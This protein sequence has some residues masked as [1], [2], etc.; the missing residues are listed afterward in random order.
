MKKILPAIFITALLPGISLGFDE[1]AEL[2]QAITATNEFAGAL[3]SEL[4]EAMQSGG[5][6]EAIEVCNTQALTISEEVSQEN[7]LTLSRVSL[8]NRN[9]GNAPNSWQAA[10]LINFENRHQAGED[11]TALTWQG[12]AQTDSGRE[13][14]FMK[15][16]PTG[17]LCLQCH[18][19]ALAPPVAEKLTE[20]YPS[21]KATGFNVGDLRGAFV[22]IRKLD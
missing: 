12:I 2:E 22:V 7:N 15:A 9:P 11:T 3:K 1:T 6:I 20:L 5:P 21:D 8:R 19:T 17:Q 14:R 10:V 4:M 16:I 13:F 18:G